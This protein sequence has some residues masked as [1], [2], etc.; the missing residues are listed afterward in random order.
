MSRND[1][2][3]VLI[4]DDSA[5][6]RKILTET[7]SGEPGLQV[8]GT[9]PDPYV[10]RDKIL[11]LQPDVITLDIE[12]P[13]M[14][15]LTFLRKLMHYHPLPVV[16]IS[17]LAQHSCRAALEALESGAVE[18]L[19]KPGG[20]YSVGELRETLAAKIRAAA[21]SRLRKPVPP[22]A[23]PVPKQ[24]PPLPAAPPAVF[25]PDGIIA[26]GASTGGIEAI[27]T[28]LRAFP[29]NAPAVVVVQHIPAG[30]SRA[31]ANRMNEVCAI[32]VK[33]A[34]DGDMLRPGLALVAPGDLH[35]VLR[36]SAAKYMVSVKTGPRV[37]YQ[38]PSVD[39]LFCSVAEAAG[40]LAVAALL[41]GMGAD[42]AQ[43]LLKLRQVG[44]HTIAQDEATC[45]VFGM[46]REAIERGAAEKVLPL[47][48]IAAALLA[49]SGTPNR[50]PDRL[51]VS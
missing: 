47:D 1:Q 12:M 23:I 30:F 19:A 42:G 44:A 11:D 17:S 35:M 15:G 31:F 27:S 29:E 45:V 14:D 9:A 18:V 37:C 7:L 3:R 21:A 40:P 6:V 38:R 41:T 48:R 32:D 33:E 46:P 16:V 49:A 36:K 43:G 2:I 10:A 8:V 51:L 50:R 26:I 25:P 28:L 24:S 34:E 39:V 20:P 22:S 5:I 4:V 13:R